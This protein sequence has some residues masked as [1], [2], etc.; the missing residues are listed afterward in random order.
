MFS[1]SAPRI[2]KETSRVDPIA[3]VA[4]LPDANSI[5]DFDTQLLNR[6]NIRIFGYIHEYSQ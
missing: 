2:Q 3:L 4:E 6:A 1:M 5:T